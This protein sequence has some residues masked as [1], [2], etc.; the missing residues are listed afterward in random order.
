[1]FLPKQEIFEKLK[2]TGI[3]VSLSGQN[4]FKKL[5]ALTFR[6]DDNSPQYGLKGEISAQ[7][8]I[9]TVD[10]WANS[11]KEASKLL[12]EIEKKMREIGYYLEFSS[13]VPNPDSSIFHINN[14]FN[15][16]KCRYGKSWCYS[17]H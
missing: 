16:K 7:E 17:R 3:A 10:I 15:S 5:P 9:A 12:S 11:S 2:E 13:D 1:M 8:I 4:I 6:I 14:R